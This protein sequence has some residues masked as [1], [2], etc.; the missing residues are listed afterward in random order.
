MTDEQDVKQALIQA[1]LPEPQMLIGVDFGQSKDYTAAV[2]VERSYDPVGNLYYRKGKEEA[3][4][5]DLEL[6]Y[7]V[8]HLERLP[9]GMPYTKQVQWLVGMLEEIGGHVAVIADATGVGRGVIDILREAIDEVARVDNPRGEKIKSIQPGYIQITAGSKL[10][11]GLHGILNVPKRD[12]VAAPL[13][14]FQ[15]ER[16]KISEDL[17]YTETLK[18]ELEN[19]KVKIN[20]STANDSYAAWREDEHDDL[21]LALALAC[22]AGE[23]FMDEYQRIMVPGIVVADAPV[24][25]FSGGRL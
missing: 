15:D 13:I 1:A 17:E 10:T 9:L 20:I 22:W 2:V 18:K 4:W 19:F 6:M 14:L 23:T 5:Q 25:T 7:A 24:H 16:L 8:R 11:R 3:S 21:V 12:L